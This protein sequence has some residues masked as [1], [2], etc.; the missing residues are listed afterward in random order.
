MS[1]RQWRKNEHSPRLSV[2]AIISSKRTNIRSSSNGPDHISSSHTDYYVT[3][4]FESKDRLEF[5]L[6]G[7]EYG[8]LAEGDLGM[9][10]F[11]GTRYIS[12]TRQ[13]EKIS[14]QN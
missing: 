2:P 4:E 6:S 10:T 14:E 5:H 9:L 8:L 11:Q 1:I 12:F 3:F 7:K 13:Q